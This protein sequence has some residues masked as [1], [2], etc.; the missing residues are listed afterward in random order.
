MTRQ[1]QPTGVHSDDKNNNRDGDCNDDVHHEVAEASDYSKDDNNNA[2]MST[3][4]DADTRSDTGLSTDEGMGAHSGTTPV[5]RQVAPAVKVTVRAA[6][7][8]TTTAAVAA[9]ERMV[10]ARGRRMHY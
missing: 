8:T 2:G 3:G 6:A 1:T 9:G 7:V 4:P 10:P 5:R